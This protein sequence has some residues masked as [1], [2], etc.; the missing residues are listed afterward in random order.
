MQFYWIIMLWITALSATAPDI[1]AASPS[2]EI[3]D[4][5]MV[6]LHSYDSELPWVKSTTMAIREAVKKTDEFRFSLNMEYLDLAQER[7]PE[8]R[9]QIKTLLRIKYQD[10]QPDIVICFDTLA[11]IFLIDYKSDLFPDI[12]VIF[13]ITEPTYRRIEHQLPAASAVV[14]NQVEHADTLDYALTL[15][16]KTRHVAVISGHTKVGHTS[17]TQLRQISTQ[18]K[19]RVRFHYLSGLEYDEILRTVESLPENSI[20]FQLIFLADLKGKKYIPAKVLEAVSQRANAPVFSLYEPLMG[21]GTIGGKMV[22]PQILQRDAVRLAVHVLKSPQT[23]SGTVWPTESKPIFDW[24]RLQQW[25]I[26]EEALPPGS[27]IRFRTDSFFQ[28][29][30]HKIIAGTGLVLLQAVL[31]IFLVVNLIRRKKTE[32]FL[33]ASK[34]QLKESLEELSLKRLVLENAPISVFFLNAQGRIFYVNNMAVQSYGFTQKEFGERT[35]WDIDPKLSKARYAALWRQMEDGH[36]FKEESVHRRKNGATFPIEIYARQTTYKNQRLNFGFILDMSMRKAAE[37]RLKSS[38]DRYRSILATAMDGFMITNPQGHLT[39]VNPAYCRMSGYSETELLSM[40]IEDLEA[41]LTKAQI[42]DRI[43]EVMEKGQIRFESRHRHKDG[44]I[45]DVDISGQYQASHG[46]YQFYFMRDITEQK[47]TQAAL[48]QSQ[49]MEAIGTLAGGIAHD[50]NNILGAILGYADL[51]LH[52]NKDNKELVDQ[53]EQIL[54][55]GLRAKGLVMQILFFSRK[56]EQKSVCLDIQPMVREISKLLKATLPPGI[57]ILLTFS[58]Q[59]CRIMADPDQIHQI[60]M[61]LC[62]NAIYAMGDKGQLSI[63]LSEILIDEKMAST[64]RELRPGNFIRLKVG[65]TGSGIPKEIKDQIF[66][67]F[68]TTKPR[69]KGTGLGLSVLHGIL[70]SHG[71]AVKVDSKPGTGTVFNVF[72]PAIQ[73]DVPAES[74]PEKPIPLGTETILLVDDEPTVVDVTTNMLESLGYTIVG[75]TDSQAAWAC[76]KNDPHR[77]DLVLTDKNMP[78][79]PGIQLAQKMLIRH[80]GLHIIM[81]TGFFDSPSLEILR[82]IGIKEVLS[83]PILPKE[84]AIAIR[85]TLDKE[86]TQSKKRTQLI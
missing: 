84:L 21:Y 11:S 39:Q 28:L 29:Y 17:E 52:R 54:H 51:I 82:E 81:C 20:V 35:I 41:V 40:T 9:E 86:R 2:G 75:F 56:S 45:F 58:G 71:G 83:K 13:S 73:G 5:K 55:A 22:T 38:E 57:E 43:L 12:P 77:F 8:Y 36:V 34:A 85:Q 44:R 59:P 53:A 30:R 66:D 80:P 18:F 27:E 47:K 72:L 64:Q 79:I 42:R 19:A 32:A 33:L 7:H 49:K 6:I 65:D 26:K 74:E 78:G 67:P 25:E 1:A 10:K 46:G 69:G 68:F 3:K 76:F 16:P 63:E 61:N 4:K 62:T 14:T 50:F 15:F 70:E 23:Y 60:I 37:D 48:R 24:R 31:I